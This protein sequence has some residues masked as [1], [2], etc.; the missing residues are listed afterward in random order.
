V[1]TTVERHREKGLPAPINSEVIERVIESEA[2]APRVMKALRLFELVDKDGNPTEQFEELRLAGTESDFKARFGAILQ[3]AYADVLQYI[4]LDTASLEQIEGQFRRY[5]PH[6]QRERMVVLFRG[7]FQFTRLMPGKAA[8][9]QGEA[10]RARKPRPA[11]ASAERKPKPASAAA[12][13]AKRSDPPVAED[14]KSRYVDLLLKQ[15]A[16]NPSDELFNRIEKVLGLDGTPAAT[17]AG[18]ANGH[19]GGDD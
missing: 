17:P 11:S 7:L 16:E 1:I 2:L 4:D 14:A 10:P 3:A 15:A 13:P 8:D 6:G 12:E 19:G 18:T 9:G 5:T